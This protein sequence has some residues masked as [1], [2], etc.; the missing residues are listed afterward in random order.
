[1]KDLVSIRML[2]CL[3]MGALLAFPALAVDWQNLDEEHYLGGRKCSVGYLQGKVTLVCPNVTLANRMEE[4][5]TS[6]K[7]KPFVLIGAY[8]KAP[9]TASYPVYRGVT[10]PDKAGESPLYVVDGTGKV[11]YYGSDERRATEVVV[12]LLTDMASP[13][14]DAQWRKFL[15]YEFATLPG[16]ASLRYAEY[17]KKFPEAAK[18]YVPK[19]AEIAKI[20]D[21]KKLADLVKFAKSVKDLRAIDPKKARMVKSRLAGKID[22]AVKK[23]AP[24]KESENP[25][26]VQEAKNAL[27]DLAWARAAL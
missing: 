22:E 19:F 9:K 20:P 3:A 21:L 17:K 2:A 13:K 1:M 18:D 23:F 11:S 12:M 7:M 6:F 26:V 14:S 24:L 15:D 5:W 4:V 16:H 25:L 10:I 27:A 8:E